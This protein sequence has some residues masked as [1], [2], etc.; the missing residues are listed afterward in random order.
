[1]LIYTYMYVPVYIH[2][3]YGIYIYI[4]TYVYIYRITPDEP[5]VHTHICNKYMCM[6]IFVYVPG[7]V[8]TYISMPMYIYMLMYLYANIYMELEVDRYTY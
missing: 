6:H 7:H 1:M 8:P 4:Y 2:H 3:I 5:Y